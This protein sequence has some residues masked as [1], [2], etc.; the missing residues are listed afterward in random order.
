MFE[1]SIELGAAVKVDYQLTR[2]LLAGLDFNIRAELFTEAGFQSANVGID[3]G[4]LRFFA[5]SLARQGLF[6]QQFGFT[7]RQ[8][9]VYHQLRDFDLIVANQGQQRAR[10]AHI[11]QALVDL[12]LNRFGKVEQ[13]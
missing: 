5:A 12:I 13:A 7:N 6:H 1:D 8:S 3:S 9:A 11:E 10:M 2:T 4:R